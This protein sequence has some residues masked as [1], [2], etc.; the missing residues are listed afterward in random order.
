MAWVE[1]DHCQ[2]AG[3][4]VLHLGELHERQTPL[5]RQEPCRAAQYV[6]EVPGLRFVRVGAEG[7]TAHKNAFNLILVTPRAS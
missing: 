6:V 2:L 1:L 7:G 5:P 3:E 4:K